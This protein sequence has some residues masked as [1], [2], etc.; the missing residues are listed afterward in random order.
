MAVIS[1]S[2]LNVAGSDLFMD[3]ESFMSDLTEQELAGT[4]GGLSP[5][6][7]MTVLVNSWWFVGGA[8]LGAA[9][10]VGAALK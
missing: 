6:L 4:N 3:S 7:V 1:I 5:I 10:A 2:N 9:G 8:V